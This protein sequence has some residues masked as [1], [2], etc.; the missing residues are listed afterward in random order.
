MTH[1]KNQSA[2]LRESG[3]LKGVILLGSKMQSTKYSRSLQEISITSYSV[4]DRLN[5]IKTQFG[6]RL[7]E[8]W[9]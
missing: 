8:V 3:G 4:D 5:V 2:T 1:K 7:R 9:K 6:P